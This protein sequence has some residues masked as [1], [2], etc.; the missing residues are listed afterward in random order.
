[1]DD[2]GQNDSRC[3]QFSSGEKFECCNELR[4]VYG[5]NIMTEETVRQWGR[6]FEVWRTTIHEKSKVVGHLQ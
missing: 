2:N 5:Q 4:A 3:Y 6:M 1:M